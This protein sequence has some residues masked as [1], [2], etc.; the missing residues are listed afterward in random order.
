[1]RKV[2]CVVERPGGQ[3]GREPTLIFYSEKLLLSPT[4]E[5]IKKSAI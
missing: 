4:T 3:G 5:K 2:V 1:M